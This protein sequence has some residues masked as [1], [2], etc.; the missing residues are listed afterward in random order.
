MTAVK[1]KFLSC[2]AVNITEVSGCEFRARITLV[3]RCLHRRDIACYSPGMFVEADADEVNNVGMLELA[4]DQGL[5][6]KIHLG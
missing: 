2:H 1:V 5:H 6:Q 4:H 3:R